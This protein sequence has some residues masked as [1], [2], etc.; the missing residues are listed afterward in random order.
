MTALLGLIA[1]VTAA[2]IT[3]S[4]MIS[5]HRQAWINALRDDLA[6]F[7][8]TIDII[9][10]TKTTFAEGAE[11][12]SLIEQQRI[13]NDAL[14]KYRKIL[15]RLNMNE[16]LHQNLEKSLGSLLTIRNLAVHQDEI[17]EAVALAR[18]ILKRE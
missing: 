14:L 12:T 15:M 10:F 17:A 18:T 11:A 2:L 7:F 8:S 9:H 16:P 1:A 3:R 13:Q 6:A 5:N 4:V